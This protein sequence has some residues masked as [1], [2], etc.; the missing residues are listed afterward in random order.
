M[1]RP[2]TPR[3]EGGGKDERFHVRTA[4]DR[5]ALC[6]FFL[7]D[8]APSPIIAPWN[9]RA[10]FLEGDAGADSSRTGAGLMS[11]IERSRSPRLS[12]MRQT[13]GSLRSN[14]AIAGYDGLRAK[15][16]RLTKNV[17][18]LEG[19]AKVHAEDELK[20]VKRQDIRIEKCI[21]SNAESYDETESSSI[22]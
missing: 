9:G 21:A 20:A 6:R 11:A 1:D 5:A 14:E 3:P 2:Q 8:Y 19:D 7:N 13:V 18:A 12:N 16:K 22:H 10:G 17:K 4:L 15:E